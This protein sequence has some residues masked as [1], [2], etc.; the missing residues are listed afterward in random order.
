MRMEYGSG[1]LN[2][3]EKAS[4]LEWLESNGLGGYASG[5]VAGAL[6][7]RYHGLLIA[8]LEPPV[9]RT[10]L[11]SKLD[12]TIVVNDRKPGPPQR[13]E[14][15]ANQYPGAVYPTGYRYLEKF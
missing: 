10:V 15:G 7:R 1:I 2:D 5:T 9:K 11:L 3:F 6:T 13:Y 12:E 4:A 14:L 8:A